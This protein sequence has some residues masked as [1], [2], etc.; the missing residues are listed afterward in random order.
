MSAVF[1]R[2]S[3]DF[4]PQGT[5]R[6]L[7]DNVLVKVLDLQLSDTLIAEWVGKPVRGV[8]VAAGPGRY[9]NVHKKGQRDGKDWRSVEDSPQFRPTEVKVGDIVELGGFDIGGYAF[10]Q[11]MVDNQLHLMVSEQD[12]AFTHG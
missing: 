2:K 8:V 11:I 3:P 4:A 9:P 1:E 6:P 5:I 10:T 7:R 12:I